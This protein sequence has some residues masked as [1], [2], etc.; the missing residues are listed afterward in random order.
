MAEKT[1]FAP[2]G[3]NQ[4]Y[5]VAYSPDGKMLAAATNDTKL[6]LWDTA[7][8][9]ESRVLQGHETG[10]HSVAWSP[11]GKRV[12]SGD[13]RGVVKLWDTSTGKELASFRAHGE[14]VRSLA[15]SP[16]GKV[17]ISAGGY[18]LVQEP[19]KRWDVTERK[20]SPW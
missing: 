1:S 16:D 15:F 12:A 10:L 19:I 13:F 18:G 6:R 11:E 5:Q 2:K 3:W 20:E 9:K 4:A 7:S 8:G 17:L 14:M